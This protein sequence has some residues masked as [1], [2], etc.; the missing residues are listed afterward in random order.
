MFVHAQRL[1]EA[2]LREIGARLE[3]LL[4]D[5]RHGRMRSAFRALKI[6]LGRE[7]LGDDRRAIRAVRDAAG[8][9][10]RLMV[11]FNQGLRLDDAQRRCHALDDEGLYWFEE[12][13]AYNDIGGHARLAR[14][15]KTP[16]QLGENFYGPRELCKALQA[17][18]CDCVMLD[19]MR[20]GGV[21]GWLR[22]APVAAAMGVPVSTHLY[23]EVCAHLMRVTE[24]A[25]SIPSRFASRDAATIPSATHSPCA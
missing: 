16:V 7:R 14:E 25:S 17:Q 8:E 23:P 4:E 21:S 2:R 20:I 19:L 6:R 9:D 22:A 1:G 24:G 18:A 10:V 3:H 13:L 15:L 5:E 12:P 11:D